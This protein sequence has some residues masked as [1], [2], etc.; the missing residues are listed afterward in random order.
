MR[1][2]PF[3][4]GPASGRDFCTLAGAQKLAAMIRAAWRD[5]GHDVPVQIVET[6]P[7]HPHTL[8]AVRM[9]TLIGGLPR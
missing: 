4:P 2:P 8:Y 3:R 5:V 1:I 9:P 6:V 7:G